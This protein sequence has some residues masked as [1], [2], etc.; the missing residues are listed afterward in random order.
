M[1][2]NT[3]AFACRHACAV[4]F[5]FRQDIP[6]TKDALRYK[7]HM[8]LGIEEEECC[9]LPVATTQYKYFSTPSRLG[10]DS[11]VYST[12]CAVVYGKYDKLGGTPELFHILFLLSIT[13]VKG[14]YNDFRP[15]VKVSPLSDFYNFN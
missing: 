12:L 4:F 6:S 7:L 14:V 8:N 11:L 9:L 10:P 2:E 5:G 15:G 13:V 1:W 3:N